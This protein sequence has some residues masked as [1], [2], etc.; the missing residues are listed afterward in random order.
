MDS[1]LEEPLVDLSLESPLYG[2]MS[3]GCN[4]EVQLVETKIIG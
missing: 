3:Q 2:T 4:F 1:I